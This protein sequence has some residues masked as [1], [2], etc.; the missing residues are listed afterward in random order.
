MGCKTLTEDKKKL[1]EEFF[2]SSYKSKCKAF[3]TESFRKLL[4]SMIPTETAECACSTAGPLSDVEFELTRQW[5]TSA[6]SIP[7][8]AASNSSPLCQNCSP[9]IQEGK[10]GPWTAVVSVTHSSAISPCHCDFCD[11]PALLLTHTPH[12]NTQIW[13]SNTSL[14]SPWHLPHLQSADKW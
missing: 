12:M 6:G 14:L 7:L 4:E 8:L 1:E 9:V 5:S 13:G 10:K 2:P 3:K 11:C